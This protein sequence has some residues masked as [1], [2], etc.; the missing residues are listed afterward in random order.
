MAT[1]TLW[2]I[3]FGLLALI[4]L[5][6]TSVWALFAGLAGSKYPLFA[7]RVKNIEDSL[8]ETETT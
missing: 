8:D 1:K 3:T 2:V 6:V 5:P 4:L 7:L